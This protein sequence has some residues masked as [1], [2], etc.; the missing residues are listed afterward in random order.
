M[1]VEMIEKEL[2]L[3]AGYVG[4]LARTASHRYKEYFVRKASGGFRQILHPAKELKTLQRWIHER[5]LSQL[6]VHPSAAAY[7]PGQ[8]LLDHVS[9]HSG[10]HYLLRMDFE[11]FFPCLRDEDIRLHFRKH[12]QLLPAE[13]SNNDTEIL[14]KFV[15]V[16]GCLTIGSVTSP[17]LSNT[18]CYD[19]DSLLSKYCQE[20]GITY[21]RYADDLFFSTKVRNLLST[22]EIQ[23]SK[24]VKRLEYPKNLCINLHKT[25]HSSKKGRMPV[26][27]LMLTPDGRVS[28]GR[29]RKRK[30]KAQVHQWDSLSK[31]EKRSVAGYL[32]YCMAVEPEFV[33]SLHRKY[34][35][36]R[37]TKIKEFMR[38]DSDKDALLK[39]EVTF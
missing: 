26:T 10:A 14:L 25:R 29:K 18:L 15:C 23:V 35:P 34:G 22:V 36:M 27:G 38:F 12:S 2:Q 24:T 16:G 33:N 30:V 37:M 21:T 20:L 32:A 6:P 31:D 17:S 3:D 8:G 11:N 1:L 28:V 7:R 13:W 19:L 9:R 39:G 4:M 5:I